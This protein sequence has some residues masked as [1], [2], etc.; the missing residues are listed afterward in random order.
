MK[1]LK[2]ALFQAADMMTKGEKANIVLRLDSLF[3]QNAAREFLTGFPEVILVA[4]EVQEWVKAKCEKI[5]P[6]LIVAYPYSYKK[7]NYAYDEYRELARKHGAALIYLECLSD[8]KNEDFPESEV[9]T[10]H[11]EEALSAGE[12]VEELNDSKIFD[13][14]VVYHNEGGVYFALPRKNSPIK[15]TDLFTSVQLE[16]KEFQE[17]VTVKDFVEFLKHLD[18]KT[19]VELTGVEMPIEVFTNSNVTIISTVKA[20]GEHGLSGKYLNLYREL[21]RSKTPSHKIYKA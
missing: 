21:R 19:V 2:E 15:S 3:A 16:G 9:I 20:T 7:E 4:G 8:L 14:V 12:L 1:S 5:S 10:C 13:N 18:E 17:S 6:K 11:T